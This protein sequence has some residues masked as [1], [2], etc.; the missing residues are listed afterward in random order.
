MA[1]L[2][3]P[4]P[5]ETIGENYQWREWFQRVRSVVANPVLSIFHNLL[6]GLQGGSVND[7]Y[8]LTLRE[9]QKMRS[10]QVLTW[11]SM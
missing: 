11:L 7:Y 9:T 6:G 1:S 5:N 2:L 4:I 3:P 10:N 8:H